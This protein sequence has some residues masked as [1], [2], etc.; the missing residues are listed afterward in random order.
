[1]AKS[2][3]SLSSTF[4]ELVNNQNATTNL[5]GDLAT[6]TTTLDSDLV[7]AINEL[8]S[9]M[10]DL[11]TLVTSQKGTIV[12]AINEI[13]QSIGILDSNLAT[14]DLGRLVDFVGDSAST[15]IAAINTTYNRIPNVYDSDGTL[16]NG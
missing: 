15:L 3:I 9:Q 6:L 14:N 8:D 1:M 11:S 12:A 7:G 13:E 4:R 5:V 16:L 10:G 2:Y